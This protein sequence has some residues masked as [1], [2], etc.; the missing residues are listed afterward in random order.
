MQ[1]NRE[2][3]AEGPRCELL[4]TTCVTYEARFPWTTKYIAICSHIRV[5]DQ[6]LSA[7]SGLPKGTVIVRLAELPDP[8]VV[9]TSLTY[10]DEDYAAGLARLRNPSLQALLYL[11]R[12]RQASQAI[13]LTREGDVIVVGAESP[14][15][16]SQALSMLGVSD[17]E[18]EKSTM[19][20]C[21]EASLQRLSSHR[22]DMLK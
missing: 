12:S 20:P 4:T 17:G 21:D 16:L 18:I 7:S 22:L 10:V 13:E 6:L 8:C 5:P 11:T 3:L 15:S 19:P 1:F 14:S 9:A 2:A